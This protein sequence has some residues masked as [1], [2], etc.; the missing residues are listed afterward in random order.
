MNGIPLPFLGLGILFV[1]MT[2]YLAKR[3]HRNP[4][5]WGVAAVFGLFLTLI[6]LAFFGDLATMSPEQVK[7]SILKERIVCGVLVVLGLLRLVAQVFHA[8]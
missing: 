5:L 1:V 2:G 3:K 4:W 8:G 7:K 6:A